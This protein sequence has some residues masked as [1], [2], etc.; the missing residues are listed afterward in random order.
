MGYTIT[1]GQLEVEK[2]PDDGLDCSCIKF[3]AQGARHD[4]APAFGEPTDFQNQRWLS[5][6]TWADFMR[7]T[8][9]YDIFFYDNGHLIGV[10][11]GVRLV[12]KELRDRV[13]EAL[14][15]F[16]QKNPSVVA[17]F[18]NGEIGGTLCRLIWLDYWINWAFEN[19]ETPVIA[20]S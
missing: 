14:T 19:C 8:G 15:S 9:L 1:I 12:T 18:G 10:H 13:T 7:S 17:E 4:T 11:P 16:S 5:Y 20:N 3:D 6:C 2:N